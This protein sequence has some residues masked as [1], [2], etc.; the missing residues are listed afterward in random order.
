MQ[1]TSD[2]DQDLQ[3]FADGA[4]TADSQDDLDLHGHGVTMSSHGNTTIRTVGSLKYHSKCVIFRRLCLL[5]N[6]LGV[7]YVKITEVYLK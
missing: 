6:K 3:V 7:C 4:F 2:I 1:L 5:L